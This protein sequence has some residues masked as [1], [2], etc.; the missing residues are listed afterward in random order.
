MDLRVELGLGERE[1]V[2]TILHP[3]SPSAKHR[4]SVR[5]INNNTG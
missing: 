3:A 5:I 1:Q 2:L 4:K